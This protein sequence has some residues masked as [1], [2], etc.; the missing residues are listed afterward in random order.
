MIVQGIVNHGCVNT[1]HYV[2]SKSYIHHILVLG[3]PGAPVLGLSTAPATLTPAL[4][5]GGL[6]ACPHISMRA[7]CISLREY[8]L[9]DGSSLELCC[10]YWHGFFT[11]D[12]TLHDYDDDTVRYSIYMRRAR[13]VG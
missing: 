6:S 10:Y 1:Y 2:N 5:M 13:R 9:I 7:L 11:L 8:Y 4:G 12:W 3:L